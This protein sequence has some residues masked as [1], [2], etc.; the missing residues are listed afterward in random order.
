MANLPT[1]WRVRFMR[2]PD[3]L[4]LGAWIVLVVALARPQAGNARDVIQG[5]GIDI[6][7]ALDIS[8]SMAALDF[9]PQNRLQAAKSVIGDFIL[10]RTFDRVGLVVFAR[11]AYH[12]VPLTL[13]YD[14]FSILLDDVQLVEDIVDVN[15]VPLLLDGTAIGLGIASAANMLR[16]S[17]NATRVIILL[18]DGDNNAAL[19]PLQASTAAHTLGIRI[20][21]VG[22]GR[23]GDVRIPDRSTG[24][25]VTVQSDL[26]EASLQEIARIGDGRYFRAE[27]LA[28]LQ[29]IYDQIDIL[30]RTD[31][32]RVVVVRWRDQGFGLLFISL[33]LLLIE[34]GLRMTVFQSHP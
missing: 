28:D 3:I 20:Y 13:D 1:T 25:I 9:E 16:G 26:D 12:Q 6:V 17:E 31:I 33:A 27:D 4:R 29:A 30:E 21:T 11:N 2:A 14:T 19:D 5:Q 8:N 34:R 32:E 10:S 24:E 15:G 22:V 18:T 7:L 23:Q